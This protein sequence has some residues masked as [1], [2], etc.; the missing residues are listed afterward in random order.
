MSQT[1]TQ[2]FNSLYDAHHKV[3]FA[4]LLGKTGNRETASDLLQETFVRVWQHRDDL[5]RIPEERRRFW[6]LAIAKNLLRDLQRKQATLWRTETEL[7]EQTES[8]PQSG[9]PHRHVEAQELKYHLTEAICL[10][11][12]QLR[13]ILTLTLV[14]EMTSASIG[15]LLDMPATTVRHQLRQ[16]RLQIS[17]TLERKER[18]YGRPRVS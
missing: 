14:G 15:T 18:E 6:L 5:E 12:E 11:P 8:K 10:L 4:Y 7:R 16:A 3:L 1:T 9:D 2:T 17:K 13:L